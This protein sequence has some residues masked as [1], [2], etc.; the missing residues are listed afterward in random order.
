MVA[1]RVLTLSG[2]KDSPDGHTAL[3]VMLLLTVAT[4]PALFTTLKVML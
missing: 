1:D 4:K 3:I 2:H